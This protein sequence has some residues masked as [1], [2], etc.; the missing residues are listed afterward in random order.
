MPEPLSLV[1]VCE[2]L[3]AWCDKHDVVPVS[4]QAGERM[5]G[6][7]IRYYRTLG[8]V[9]APEG[10][11]YG[12]KHLFQLRAVRLLQAQGLPLRRVRELLFGRSLTELRTICERGLAEAAQAAPQRRIILPVAD[13]LW[14]M[15]PLDDDFLLVSRRGTSVTP[16]QHDAVRAALQVRFPTP[17]APSAPNHRTQ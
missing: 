9:D 12:E 1:D 4:G 17:S 8:L 5:T 6:R 14:R 2:R 3:N 7:S 13:E 11:A 10:G 16:A 15:I